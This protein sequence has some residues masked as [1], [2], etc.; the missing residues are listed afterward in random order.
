MN[1]GYLDSLL[2]LFLPTKGGRYKYLV[3]LV[4][5]L[6]FLF[7]ID[8]LMYLGIAPLFHL[9]PTQKEESTTH[10]MLSHTRIAFMS[11]RSGN[12]DIYTMGT[13]GNTLTR[14]TDNP[15]KDEYPSWSPDGK[16]IAFDSDRENGTPAIYVMNDDGTN[17]MR[18]TKQGSKASETHPVWSPDG[19]KIAFVRHESESNQ[20]SALYTMNPDGT[21]ITQLTHSYQKQSDAPSWSPDSQQIAYHAEQDGNLGI[22]TMDADGSN[23]KNIT[24]NKNSDEGM[25]V[26]SP[27]GDKIAF[28]SNRA[29]AK[30]AQIY[31]MKPDGTEIKPLSNVSNESRFPGAF[32]PDGQWIAYMKLL[33]GGEEIAVMRL[34]GQNDVSIT[35][36]NAKNS[37]MYATNSFPTWSQTLLSPLP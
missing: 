5:I 15:T 2:M 12:F 33:P 7:F 27:F 37:R 21:H 4:A 19:K 6:T 20:K 11:D 25:P 31:T 10:Q 34:S 35:N 8:R 14:L 24:H 16:H 26:W 30:T 1:K 28:Y 22:Y 17:V 18:L 3:M 36:N 9:E 29:D 13:E 32:S 23:R